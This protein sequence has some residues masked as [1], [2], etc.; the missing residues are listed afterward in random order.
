[1]GCDCGRA[2][3]AARRVA[4]S[5][6]ERGT[7]LQS[8]ASEYNSKKQEAVV[9]EG[10]RVSQGEGGVGD[11]GIPSAQESVPSR[12][13]CAGKKPPAFRYSTAAGCT[14][15]ALFV[16]GSKTE[17]ALRLEF[18]DA[19]KAATCSFSGALCPLAPA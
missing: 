7:M 18:Y 5:K 6:L 9:R 16:S 3:D 17:Q 4:R 15:R 10:G 12:L 19:A 13:Q 1:M 14:R 11:I 2:L 8:W